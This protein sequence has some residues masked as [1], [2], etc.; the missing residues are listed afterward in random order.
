MRPQLKSWFAASYTF[1]DHRNL[2]SPNSE[3]LPQSL[4]AANEGQ[5][6]TADETLPLNHRLVELEGY[7]DV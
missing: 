2:K 4:F 7:I 3:V 5:I 1:T 6:L